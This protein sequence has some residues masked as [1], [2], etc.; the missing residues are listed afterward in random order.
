MRFKL[1]IFQSY[2]IKYVYIL[3]T[4]YLYALYFI[5]PKYNDTISL[6]INLF[7]KSHI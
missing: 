1:D 5:L 6:R 4:L 2:V 3:Y 7:I